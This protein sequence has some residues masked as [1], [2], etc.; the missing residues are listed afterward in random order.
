M[1]QKRAK[2]EET[3]TGLFKRFQFRGKHGI[4]WSKWFP[5]SGTKEPTQYKGLKNEYKE[6]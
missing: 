4:E 3:K 5:Y 2:Y 6:I 1:A